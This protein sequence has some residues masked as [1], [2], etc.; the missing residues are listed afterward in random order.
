ML[1]SM[2]GVLDEQR[3][4]ILKGV[5]PVHLRVLES[6]C[7]VFSLVKG[8]EL[9]R[10][11]DEPDGLY[12]I[13]EGEFAITKMRR[14]KRLLVATIGKGEVF[15]E[16][17]LLHDK[18]R[19]AGVVTTRDSKVAH[20][21]YSAVRQVTEVD[22]ALQQRLTELMNYRIV[23]TFF[24]AH[25]IFSSLSREQRQSLQRL[26]TLKTLKTGERLIEHGQRL[27]AVYLVVSGEIAVEAE[28]ADGAVMLVDIRRDG[29]LVGEIP[30]CNKKP[31][32]GTATAMCESDVLVLDQAAMEKIKEL[33]PGGHVALMTAI[34]TLAQQTAGRIKRFIAG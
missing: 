22:R 18:T 16:Y 9:I 23:D 27:D 3:F 15:G 19:Y 30:F 24:H 12:F 7:R 32:F 10:E 2:S 21:A 14:E 8:V 17:G 33:H 29:G 25:P 28:D 5:S 6:S 26:I 13:I 4:P 34:K 11:G 20:V 31:N 1:G